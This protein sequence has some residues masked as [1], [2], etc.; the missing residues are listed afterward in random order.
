M[1][2][3]NPMLGEQP[4]ME[5]MC[6]HIFHTEC[7]V[8]EWYE[9]EMTCPGCHTNV[10]NQHVRTASQIKLQESTKKREETFLEEYTQNKTLKQ[11]IQS[12]KKQ[13]SKLRRAKAAFCK[14]GRQKQR[15]WKQ[16]IQPLFQLLRIKQKD[17]LRIVQESPQIKSWRIERT[18]LSRLEN[19][20][21]L[22]YPSYRF[23]DLLAFSSLKLPGVYDYRMMSSMY[24]WTTRRFFRLRM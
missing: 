17:M 24:R 3:A 13:V 14:F 22:K 21:E 15:E 6:A 12:I 7:L 18:K 10:F 23:I 1:L 2:C 19:R 8:L 20:F 16:E 5:L 4:K 9:H 11:D